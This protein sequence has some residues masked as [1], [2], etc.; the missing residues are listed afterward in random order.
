MGN[1]DVSNPK[2]SDSST[3]PTPKLNIDW[4]T[5]VDLANIRKR[6]RNGVGNESEKLVTGAIAE[7][8]QGHYQALKYLFEMIGLFPSDDRQENPQQQFL[9]QILLQHLGIDQATLE[10]R[11]REAGSEHKQADA[12]E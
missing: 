12:V 9:A 5:P 3:D 8:K 10:K 1:S 6:I 4:E 7:A 11:F 2:S